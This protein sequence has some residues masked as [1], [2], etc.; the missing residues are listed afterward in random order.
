MSEHTLSSA[1]VFISSTFLDMQ[2]ERDILSKRVFP[3]LRRRFQGQLEA[4]REIDLR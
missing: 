3:R 1:K 4:I 2:N